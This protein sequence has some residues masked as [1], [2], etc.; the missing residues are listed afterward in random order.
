[1]AVG[2]KYIE[3]NSLA[4]KR[5]DLSLEW[6]PTLN[7]DLTPEM[8]T[9]SNGKKVWW[10]CKTNEEH[11]WQSTVANRTGV[12]KGCPYCCGQKVC[13]DNCL[14]T[15]RAELALQWHPTLNGDLTPEMV[16]AG[17]GKKAWWVCKNNG[18]HYWEATVNDRAGK[19][20]GGC[21]YCSGKKV[22][23]DNCLATSHPELVLQW[24]PTLNG[25][26]TPEMATAGSNKKVWWVCNTKGH[27]WE[28]FVYNRAGKNNNGCPICNAEASTSIGEQQ[29]ANYVESLGFTIVRNS[30]ELIPPFELDIY[31]P[32]LNKAIEFDGFYW[33]SFPD[34]I[35]RDKYKNRLCTKKGIQLLRIPE[36]DWKNSQ[37]VTKEVIKAF[38]IPGQKSA[39]I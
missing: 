6:H 4:V 18:E 22:C 32:S 20:K 30:R 24:H 7:G 13:I 8:V 26:L 28:A 1:M 34:A 17:S 3:T 38:L 19:D 31:I 29:V 9:A 10:T 11:H 33:H 12:N 23:K 14:A 2:L 16:T 35:K 21:P 15:R 36:M 37:E 39:T 5:P 27:S 25:D